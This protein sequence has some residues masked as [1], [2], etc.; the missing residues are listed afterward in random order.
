V[1]DRNLRHDRHVDALV[2]G[3]VECDALAPD[4]AVLGAALASLRGGRDPGHRDFRISATQAA[5]LRRPG[6]RGWLR[7][8]T[9]QRIGI[10]RPLGSALTAIAL[11]GLVASSV[12]AFAP[13]GSSREAADRTSISGA[14]GGP[15]TSAAAPQASADNDF[16][17]ALGSPK[18]G[19]T[20]ETLVTDAGLGSE[21]PATAPAVQGSGAAP[22]EGI[23]NAIR[24]VSSA[25]LLAGVLLLVLP[26]LA[27]GG[28][29]SREP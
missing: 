23:P 20:P 18:A 8:L 3:C 22:Q 11:V 24:V 17:A 29:A 21:A 14:A 13:G 2:A 27:R 10:T 5:K 12:P 9:T 6:L 7:R 1:A 19:G 16:G 26:R 15:S 28:P 4:L 25:L